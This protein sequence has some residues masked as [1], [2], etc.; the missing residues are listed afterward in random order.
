MRRVKLPFTSGLVIEFT[1][2][3]RAIQQVLKW[4]EE[5]TWYPV[6]V[7]GPEGCGKTAWLK[8]ATEILRELGFEVIYVDPLHR[9]F[10]AYTD[11]SEVVRKLSDALAEV[12]GVVQLKLAT[13]AID[14][15]K[16]LIGVWRKKRVAV[17]VDEVFQAVGLD[18]AE[19]YVKMLLNLIEYP[20][21]TYERIVAIVA[22]SEGL[23][24]SRIGRHRW[25]DLMSMWNMSID[26]FK[27]L[28]EKI[29][30]PKPEFESIWKLTGGNPDILRRLYRAGWN[31]EKVITECIMGKEISPSFTM[32]WRS[33]LEKAV[34]DPDT[35]WSPETPRELIDELIA[36]NLIMYNMYD[37]DNWFWI[38]K[39]PPRK[40]LDL[41]IGEH[42]TWQTPIHREAVR[43]S[44]KEL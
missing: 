42:V 25:A 37:R 27:E 20:P 39:P 3:D 29:P 19:I 44:L 6:V 22:T 33:W 10:I 5:G 21:E 11:V 23:T 38:D 30:D 8:Q 15:V 7:Y 41:G 31:V 14:V 18:K 1:D 16:E 34:E 24:R 12:V 32:R 40:D 2:R 35:L 43:R 4:G 28:Y 17:L 13:L 26:G 9:D 36:K